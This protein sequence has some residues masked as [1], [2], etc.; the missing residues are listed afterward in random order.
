MDLKLFP[1]DSQICPLEIESCKLIAVC[2]LS[3]PF[4]FFL[5]ALFPAASPSAI[6]LNIAH[7]FLSN[8]MFADMKGRR[9]LD[10]CAMNA[11][12]LW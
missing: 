1:M 12:I 7:V 10:A 2:L 4:S 9:Q 3:S 5:F 6:T 11:A 8:A